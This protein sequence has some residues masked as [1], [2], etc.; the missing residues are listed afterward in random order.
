MYSLNGTSF[1]PHTSNG[2]YLLRKA[3]IDHTRPLCKCTTPSP[4]MYIANVRGRYIVKR[5]PS[6]G[7]DHALD[8]AS[9][10]PPEELSG[11][12]Q[13]QSSA[14]EELPDEGT[15][16]LKLDFPLSINGKRMPPPPPSEVEPTARSK[17][18]P[19]HAIPLIRKS[20]NGNAECEVGLLAQNRVFSIDEG[21]SGGPELL[22]L[23][24]ADN[25]YAERFWYAHVRKIPDL[26]T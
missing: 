26:P 6:T 19:D 21:P 4:E 25:R 17:P 16:L 5:M 12:S 23:V 11:L 10:L 14:I 9:Y 24:F 7:D 22:A 3:H 1:E 15:T 20:L 18:K 2:Q 8:C 13:T